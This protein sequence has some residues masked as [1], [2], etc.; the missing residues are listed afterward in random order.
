MRFDIDEADRQ[1]AMLALATLALERPGFNDA[2]GRLADKMA[3]YATFRELKRL[4]K[5]RARVLAPTWPPEVP[6]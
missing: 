5:D 2:L 1:L 4:N 3:G 6:R